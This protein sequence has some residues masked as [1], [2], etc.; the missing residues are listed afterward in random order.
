MTNTYTKNY[1]TN[2]IAR[3]DFSPDI[4]DI[5]K[6]LRKKFL[7]RFPILEPMK[8]VNVTGQVKVEPKSKFELDTGDLQT[9]FV[10]FG[11]Q[12]EKKM[13]IGPSYLILH[14]VND[15]PSFEILREEFIEIV[16]AF[17]ETFTDIEVNRLGLRYINEISLLESDPLNWEKYL[18][19]NL[20]SVFNI[21]ED[22]STIARGFNNIVIN[23]WPLMINFNYGMHNPDFPA[24]IK[25][26]VFILDYD[27]YCTSPQELDDIESN[28]DLAHAEIIKMF[29]DNIEDEL[30]EILN[31][32]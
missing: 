11:R 23:K 12:R 9:E 14:Y 25:K 32:K 19:K 1:L 31:E 30:R 26:K 29:E 22:K 5:P 10:Y 13:S 24:S 16:K 28:I 17:M 4:K 8:F 27:A 2:V 7:N 21:V 6:D 20:L 18:N 15:Y 3:I